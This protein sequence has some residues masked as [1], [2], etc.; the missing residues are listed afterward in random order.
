MM[1]S[2]LTLREVQEGDL[3]IFFEQQLDPEASRMAA[4]PSRARE[5][6]MAHWTK[7]M[8]E[9]TSV[10]KTIIFDGQ[11][12]GNIVYWEQSG[13]C[14]IGYWVGKE[15]WGK[16]IASAALSQFLGLVKVRP[17]Y[18]RVAKHNI[19]SVRV[20]E[21]CGFTVSGEDKFCEADG[22]EGEEFVMR[23][24]ATCSQMKQDRIPQAPRPSNPL[25][26]S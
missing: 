3:P 15:Y 2:E 17:L 16:G 1:A 23:L 22:N 8:A 7:S 12:A 26:A 11:V 4:F 20:L 24:G 25:L 13:E 21:K 9:K 14:K 10:L 5:A 18:A 19:A 6:F